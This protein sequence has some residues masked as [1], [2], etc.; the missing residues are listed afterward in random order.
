ML[1]SLG[2]KISLAVTFM[3]VAIIVAVIIIVNIMARDLVTSI[4]GEAA[5]TASRA[6]VQ[7]LERYQQEAED[8]ARLIT[9]SAGHE[10]AEMITEG[11]INMLRSIL[12]QYSDGMDYLTV[13]DINGNVIV[14]TNSLQSGDNII[15]YDVIT[16]A[17][18]GIA[19]STISRD[20]SLGSLAVSG[21]SIIR[22]HYGMVVGAI[23]CGHDLSNPEHLERIS[24]DSNAELILFEGD[25]IINTTLSDDDGNRSIGSRLDD[26]EI[27]NTVF[28]QGETFYGGLVTMY[29]Q[30]F[31]ANYSPLIVDDQIIGMMFAGSNI[32]NILISQNHMIF[33][34]IAVSSVLGVAGIVMIILMSIFMINRPLK[35][36]GFFADK[37]KAGQLGISNQSSST[38]DVR[39]SDEIGVL[40]RTLEQSY[41]QLKGYIDEIKDRMQDLADG[42]L[43]KE[44]TYSFQGDFTLIKDSINTISQNINNT[45]SEIQDSSR[46]VAFG[47]KQIS[48]S[49]QLIAEGS[50]DQ[51][52]AVQSLLT[53]INGIV[54]HVKTD[55]E[56][57]E[58][59]TSL[60]GSIM[61]NAEVGTRQ[62]NEM[63]AAVKDIENSSKSISRVIKVIDDI[64]FQTNILALNAAVEAA[65]AGQHGKGFAVVADEVRNLAAKSAKAAKETDVL[66]TDSIEKSKMGASMVD[67]TAASLKKIVSSIGE[68]NEI[69]HVISDSV[70]DQ[71]KL[72]EGI[73]SDIDKVSQVTHQTND[74]A[75]QSAASAEELSGQSATLESLLSQF[76]L[77]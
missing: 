28:H 56:N 7:S 24:A 46:Q 37:I 38:I 29:G 15:H 69:M 34:I 60:T 63:T 11:D 36:I 23:K 13:V 50:T 33:L 17:L 66:I 1:K 58:R 48:D 21:A 73:H 14:R 40:A 61:K 10:I 27:L 55:R 3:I 4:S 53:A 70:T 68:N 39:S 62:M 71:L 44:S 64:A 67:E 72:I 5:Q 77:K 20:G 42:D 76:K 54:N 12:F 9:R 47:S 52:A 2:V 74:T 57:A 16:D 18:A 30:T 45:M 32:E 59:A 35:K 19:S 41:S 22:S 51:S 65:R 43:S 8:R 31:A 6:F 25:T 75:V 26:D 49:A